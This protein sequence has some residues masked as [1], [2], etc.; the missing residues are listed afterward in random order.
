[1]RCRYETA[2]KQV[3]QNTLDPMLRREE[4]SR[5]RFSTLAKFK[6]LRLS[7]IPTDNYIGAR[8]VEVPR[9][10]GK[11]RRRP[12]S[13]SQKIVRGESS[14]VFDADDL[15]PMLLCPFSSFE[16]REVSL[17][18]LSN[19]PTLFVSWISVGSE[20]KARESNTGRDQ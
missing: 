1:M 3:M 16:D 17:D 19:S 9:A 12:L 4:L 2:I 14:S 15:S 6:R 20:F 8:I 7:N 13:K 11:E 10:F 5:L 18:L